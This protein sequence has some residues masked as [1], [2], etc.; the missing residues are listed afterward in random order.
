MNKTGSLDLLIKEYPEGRVSKYVHNLKVGQPIQIKG[1]FKKYDYEANKKNFIG[2]V[3]GGTGITPMFQLLCTILENPNDKTKVRLIF[4]NIAE[5]DI[6][7][8]GWLDSLAKNYSDRFQVCL[9]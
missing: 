4:A 1:P 3:A 6:L 8:K 5:E 9:F 7:L 2:M